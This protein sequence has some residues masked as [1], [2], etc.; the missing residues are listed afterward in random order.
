[1]VTL[2]DRDVKKILSKGK[3]LQTENLIVVYSKNNLGYPRFAYILSK[4]FSRKAVVRNRAKRIIKEALKT[5]Y[6]SL[7]DLSY[8]MIF[9][10]KK[11]IIGKKTTDLYNDIGKL[12]SVLREGNGQIS[13]KLN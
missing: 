7:K 8:D 9:I 4:K 2:K 11:S 6:E 13:D 1:M 3:S 12:I 10:A 5:Y